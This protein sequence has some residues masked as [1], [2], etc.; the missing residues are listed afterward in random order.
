[1]KLLNYG[2]KGRSVQLPIIHSTDALEDEEFESL[3]LIY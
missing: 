2:Q 1:M 3:F